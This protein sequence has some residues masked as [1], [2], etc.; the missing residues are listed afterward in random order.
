MPQLQE[1]ACAEPSQAW[2]ARSAHEI[3]LLCAL[4]VMR[5]LHALA[6]RCEWSLAVCSAAQRQRRTRFVN[7]NA[8]HLHLPGCRS[9]PRTWSKT[10]DSGLSQT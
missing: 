1:S 8:V 2:L 4:C 9:L 5:D 6:P 3:Q 10:T 7:F